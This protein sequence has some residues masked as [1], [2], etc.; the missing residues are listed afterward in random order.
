MK[1]ANEFCPTC[2]RW[3]GNTGNYSDCNGISFSSG[4]FPSDQKIHCHSDMLKS[5]KSN[6]NILKKTIYFHNSKEDNDGMIMDIEEDDPNFF[7]NE[8][9]KHDFLYT[10]CEIDVDCEIHPDGKVF[11]THLMGKKLEEKVEI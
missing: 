2:E 1:P 3:S 10:G 5:M 9:A 6:E 7:T 11:A 4:E 8:Q